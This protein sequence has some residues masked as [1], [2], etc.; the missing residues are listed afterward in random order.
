MCSFLRMDKI[1]CTF[2]PSSPAVWSRP[3]AVLRLV[4][5]GPVL[6]RPTA[7][8]CKVRGPRRLHLPGRTD[9]RL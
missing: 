4:T 6:S 3:T 8:R 7:V 1:M 2:L 5:S 9:D